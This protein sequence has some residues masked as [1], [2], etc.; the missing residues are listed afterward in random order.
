MREWLLDLRRT[1]TTASGEAL[2][3]QRI[4][5]KSFSNDEGV[6][7]E[8]MV[9]LGVRD[10]AFQH[11]LDLTGDALV[12]EFEI[13]QGLLDFLATDQLR[14]EVQLLRADAQHAQNSLS[15]VVLESALSFWLAH[16]TSSWP[17]CR[18]RD[19]NRYGSVQTRRTCG[20]SCLQ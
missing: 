10:G 8:T 14:D 9:V 12:A 17:S 7:V 11:L 6:G 20:R 19:R 16:L 3:Y 15:L 4:T 5:N 18:Q 2:H 1:A 13:G